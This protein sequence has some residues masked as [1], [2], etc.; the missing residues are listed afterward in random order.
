MTPFRRWLDPHGIARGHP[1]ALLGLLW[2]CGG[3]VTVASVPW[4]P[5]GDGSSLGVLAVGSFSSVVGAALLVVRSRDFPRWFYVA[6][7][8]LGALAVSAVLVFAGTVGTG[9]ATILY[10]FV[11]SFAFIAL[12]PLAPLI[13][14]ASATMHAAL[15]WWLDIP[16]GP[17]RWVITWGVVSVT[18]LL[19]GEVVAGIRRALYEQD[20]LVARLRDID[21]TKTTFLHAVSHEL[22]GPTTVIV[23]L[24]ETLARPELTEEQRRHL[25]ARLARRAEGLRASLAGLLDLSEV[26]EGPVPIAVEEVE[27]H[28]VVEHAVELSEV[29]RRRLQV[30][31]VDGR[32]AADG[33]KLA[34]AI[35][36][37]LTNAAKYA[38]PGSLIDV[39]A[40]IRPEIVIVRVEDRGPGVPDG[41][42]W[43]IF[44]PFERIG[45][46]G[47]MEGSGLGLSIVR[48]F[49][50]LHG[51]DAWVEP[52]KGGGSRFTITIARPEAEPSLI[53]RARDPGAEDGDAGSEG[54][55]ADSSPD[56][57]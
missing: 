35:A 30:R 32:I 43:R 31:D 14:T 49:A 10:V 16:G 38:P 24:A 53:E 48:Q 34:H 27:L 25:V 40:E 17:G 22:A 55:A 33:P 19:F 20:Q 8:L 11:S 23:G 18:G 4:G 21:A 37:L 46:H 41:L 54:P 52:R 1:T 3:A 6:M 26:G 45:E 5:Y 2:L 56:S 42:R 7:A 9:A 51:G 44:E 12:R 39:N 57:G 15:L 36:N 50:R 29:D 47:E 28:G 13:V